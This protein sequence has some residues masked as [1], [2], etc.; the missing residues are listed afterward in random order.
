MTSDKKSNSPIKGYEIV[1]ESDHGKEKA[2]YSPSEEPKSPVPLDR[3]GSGLLKPSESPK[4]QK[5]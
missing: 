5:K 2:G 3:T 4:D 1:K